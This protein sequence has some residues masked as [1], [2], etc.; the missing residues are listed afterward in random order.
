VTHKELGPDQFIENL[1]GMCKICCTHVFEV[2]VFDEN[3]NFQKTLAITDDIGCSKN[4]G[5]GC[6]IFEDHLNQ[7]LKVESR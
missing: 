3:K 1:V 5:L 7:H 6:Q 4:R 2:R